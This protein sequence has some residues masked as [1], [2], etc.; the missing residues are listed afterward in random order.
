MCNTIKEKNIIKQSISC[1]MKTIL[2]TCLI[3]SIISIYYNVVIFCF[4]KLFFPFL[5]W[6]GLRRRVLFYYIHSAFLTA[7]KRPKVKNLGKCLRVPQKIQKKLSDFRPTIQNIQN[8]IFPNWI[9]FFFVM[10]NFW[11]V[12]CCMPLLS[13]LVNDVVQ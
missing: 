1:W 13:L 10:S 5:G 2:I 4:G 11:F 12:A 8:K 9:V 3:I 7:I 6:K